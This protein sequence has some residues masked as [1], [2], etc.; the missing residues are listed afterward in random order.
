MALTRLLFPDPG[1]LGPVLGVEAELGWPEAQRPPRLGRP[2]PPRQLGLLHAQECP[3]RRVLAVLAPGLDGVG[4]HRPCSFI[5][6]L[7]RL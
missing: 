4:C 7:R 6:L 3:V 2:G 1:N 5:E